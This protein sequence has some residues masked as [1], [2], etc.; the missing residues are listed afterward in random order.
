[1]ERLLL[2]NFEPADKDMEQSNIDAHF[3]KLIIVGLSLLN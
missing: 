3:T 2:G 1:M